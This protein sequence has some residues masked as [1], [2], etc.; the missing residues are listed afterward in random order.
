MDKLHKN[1][2]SSPIWRVFC[3]IEIPSQVRERV[4]RHAEQLQMKCPDVQASWARLENIHLTLKFFGNLS[5]ALVLKASEAAAR[6]VSGLSPFKISVEGAGSFPARGPARV[7]WIGIPDQ[8]GVL[9][10]LQSQLE[11]ECEKSGFVREDRPFHPHLTVARLRGPG[12]ARALAQAHSELDFEP[13]EME[14]SEL[15]LFSSELSSKGSRYT[16]ISTHRLKE[17]PQITQITQIK[18]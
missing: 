14:V 1:D 8:R 5:Q 4:V 9:L 10:R 15:T 11:A 6:A 3:A 13:S 7:L 16:V 2:G 12:G 17:H 18:N